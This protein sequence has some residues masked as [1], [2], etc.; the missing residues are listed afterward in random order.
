MTGIRFLP[1]AGIFL[2]AGL[3]AAVM[4]LAVLLPVLKVPGL[5]LSPQ[6]GYCNLGSCGFAQPFQVKAGIYCIYSHNFYIFSANF[7]M[8]GGSK[9]MQGIFGR[10][11]FR[12]DFQVRS[13]NR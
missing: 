1:G 12:C 5:K 7:I 9:I 11:C 2:F 13:G 3:D 8:K 6:S 4:R 10:H